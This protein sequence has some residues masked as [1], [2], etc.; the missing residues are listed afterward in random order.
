MSG[1]IIVGYDGSPGSTAALE[2]AATAAEHG[3]RVSVMPREYTVPAL[4]EAIAGYFAT[5]P[6][7]ALRS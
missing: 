5:S 2:W 4:A 1:H 6:P 3:L 7:A